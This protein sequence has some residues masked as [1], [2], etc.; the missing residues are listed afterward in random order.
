M[1]IDFLDC[2]NEQQFKM[3]YIKEILKKLFDEVFC[4]ETEETVAGF[5]DVMCLKHDE[6]T[7][8]WIVHFFEFKISNKSGKIKFQP[9]Q[10]AFY[11]KHPDLNISVVALNRKN[12]KVEKFLTDFLFVEECSYCL[13]EKA[14]VQL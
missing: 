11:K 6:E 10:P 2:Q 1:N 5:P 7:N 12:G 3:K 14:E 9:T 8:E 13:N 4:I